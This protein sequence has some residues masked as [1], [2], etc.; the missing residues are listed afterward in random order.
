MSA[1]RYSA[2]VYRITGQD[3]TFDHSDR[4]IKVGEH[5]GGEKAAHARTE[6]NGS[7][8]KFRHQIPWSAKW[9]DGNADSAGTVLS[10]PWESTCLS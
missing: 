2:A 6:D 8:T 7:V 4:P 3:V 9:I 10:R 5:A 1:L